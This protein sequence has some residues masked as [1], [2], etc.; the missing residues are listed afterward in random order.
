MLEKIINAGKKII[1]GGLLLAA[2]AGCDSEA[3]YWTNETKD[4]APTYTREETHKNIWMDEGVVVPSWWFNDYSKP[5]T[6][7]TLEKLHELGVESITFVPTWYQNSIDS[8]E[9]Y[10]SA[11]KTPD[12]EALEYAITKAK[13]LGMKVVLKPHVDVWDGNWRG[14]IE[15]FNEADWQD[16]FDSYN[17]FII[18]YAEIAEKNNVDD[19]IVGTELKQTTDR[20]E[21]S[22]RIIPDVKSVF[23]GE[24][25]YA[26]NW[27]NYKNVVFWNDVDYIGVCAYF[28]LTGDMDP[29]PEELTD[30]WNVIAQ[31]LGDYA[32]SQGK[33][34]VITEF[35]YQ[36]RDGTNVTPWWVVNGVQD[37]QEQA[38]CFN[39][40]FGAL[41]N[42]SW[43]KGV[44]IWQQYYNMEEDHDDF[45]FVGKAAEFVIGNWYH[46][47]D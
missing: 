1:A 28:P 29:T 34:M 4:S 18:H 20:A 17:D 35:G 25:T 38:D 45:S 22:S 8:T 27:D 46:L 9:I 19:L 2:L 31:E 16:W 32:A 10:S 23:S 42:K 13:S 21:W 11:T 6:E 37:E 39:S 40:A 5:A 44:Y 30:A 43:V 41:F 33:Q 36:S 3:E 47:E 15:H 14:F 7:A 26:A 12:D 24:L